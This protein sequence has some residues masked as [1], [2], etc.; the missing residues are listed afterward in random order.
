MKWN[1][2]H[3]SKEE[4]LRDIL[5]EGCRECACACACEHALK[6]AGGGV[7]QAY[8]QGGEERGEKL[9][10][11]DAAASATISYLGFSSKVAIVSSVTAGIS[12]WLEWANVG[13]KMARYN[14]RWRP[15]LS[16]LDTRF[17]LTVTLTDRQTDR[18]TDSQTDRQTE[19]CDAWIDVMVCKPTPIHHLILVY[20]RELRVLSCVCTRTHILAFWWSL[21]LFCSV[22]SSL[23][24]ERLLVLLL[25]ICTCA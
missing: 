20:T 25:C 18:L 22:P 6:C 1:L 5:L 11:G 12:A 23:R 15:L 13:R 21:M 16:R 8:F 2:R 17:D 3:T 4:V 10:Y 9:I 19:R 7:E 24:N 14:T